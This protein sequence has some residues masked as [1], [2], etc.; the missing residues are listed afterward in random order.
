MVAWANSP[1][2]A[3]HKAAG[4]FVICSKLDDLPKGGSIAI[5]EEGGKPQIYLH[6]G[7]ISASGVTLSDSLLKIGKRL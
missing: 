3:S 7:H 4:T 6:T 5:V 1:E 2:A